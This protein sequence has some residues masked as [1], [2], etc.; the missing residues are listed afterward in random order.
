MRSSA[1]VC[2]SRAGGEQSAL[3]R[4][5]PCPELPLMHSMFAR[6]T[7]TTSTFSVNAQRPAQMIYKPRDSV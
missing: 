6:P 5:T 3:A 4:I 7:T 2:R 1:G